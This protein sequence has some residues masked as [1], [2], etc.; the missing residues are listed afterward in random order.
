VLPIAGKRAEAL[1]LVQEA[2]AVL[3][4]RDHEASLFLEISCC[5]S[6]FPAFL[7]RE[8]GALSVAA[9]LLLRLSCQARVSR[10]NASNTS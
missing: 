6:P 4:K 10:V 2:P 9:P 3:Q 1:V 5:N 8:S 7:R